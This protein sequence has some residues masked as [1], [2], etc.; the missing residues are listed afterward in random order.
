MRE[1]CREFL[2][3]LGHIVRSSTKQ[4]TNKIKMYQFCLGDPCQVLAY[5]PYFEGFHIISRRSLVGFDGTD[6][7]I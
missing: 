3:N 7:F 5:G 1:E 4:S 2:V 6:V